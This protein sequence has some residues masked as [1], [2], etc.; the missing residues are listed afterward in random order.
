[1]AKRLQTP[2][3]IARY[4]KTTVPYKWDQAAN[5]SVVDKEEGKY[6]LDIIFPES[7]EAK[8][9]QIV[10]DT[11][12]EAKVAFDKLDNLPYS[13]EEDED[14]NPTGNIVVKFGQKSKNKDGTYNRVPHVDAKAKPIPFAE[15]KLWGGSTVIAEYHPFYYKSGKKHGVTFYLDA[16]QIVKAAEGNT[17]FKPQ[18]DADDD[19]D[20]TVE[21]EATSSETNTDF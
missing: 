13:I 15:V 8:F 19:S 17:G 1:M 21:N 10:T 4:P 16:V 3:G 11:A 6:S 12:T 2:R 18:E 9:K 14:G 7:L 20:D 5:K